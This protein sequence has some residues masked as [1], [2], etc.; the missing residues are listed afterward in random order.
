MTPLRLLQVGL[1]V[2]VVAFVVVRSHPSELWRVLQDVDAR[3]A[4]AALLLNVPV[5][6]LAPLR[7]YL[8]YRRL[9]H[10]V[11]A[12][13]VV[14]TT[15]VGFVAGGLTP[16]ASGELLRAQS[17]RDRAAV[18][19]HDVV[20][21]VVYERALS[22]YVLVLAAAFIAAVSYLSPAAAASA[23]VVCLA[24]VLAPWAGAGLLSA[25]K[26]EDR[27]IE[28]S[29]IVAR[30][31]RRLLSTAVQIRF[32]MQDVKLLLA[33]SAISLVIFALI[34]LQYW[35]FARGVNADV[36]IGDAWI[37]LA[38]STF[39]GIVALIPLGLG[40]LDGSL[41]ATLDRLGATL[42]QGAAVVVLVRALVTLPLV[43]IAALCYVLLQ[44][45][46]A[47]PAAG[48]APVTASE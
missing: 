12:G 11:A 17:L 33:T 42:E 8:V 40:I 44:R 47:A 26:L 21:A 35:L 23:G 6:L 46:V 31:A 24:L 14:P 39:A 27:H 43:L 18:S 32:L 22:V 3:R 7:S 38:I 25:F 9:G 45:R 15:I 5:L 48:S 19:F 13:V 10:S 4:L 41:A 29:G 20:T 30:A 36:G 2:A 34:A 37:A 16:G 1:A 28:G